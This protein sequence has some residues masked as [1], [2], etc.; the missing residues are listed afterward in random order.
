MG[1][2]EWGPANPH[3]KIPKKCQPCHHWAARGHERHKS[4]CTPTESGGL[5]RQQTP[6][7]PITVDGFASLAC[8]CLRQK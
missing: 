6:T 2:R 8:L 7:T 5:V 4:L 1:G 3:G